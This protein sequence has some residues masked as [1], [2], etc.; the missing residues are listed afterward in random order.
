MMSR[1]VPTGYMPPATS[2]DKLKK[3]PG[4]RDLTFESCPA[5]ENSTRAAILHMNG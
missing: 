5:A 4:G 2:R 1:S 3:L